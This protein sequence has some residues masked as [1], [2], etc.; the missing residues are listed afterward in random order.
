MSRSLLLATLI[1]I[2]L[3]PAAQADVKAFKSWW[4]T[5]SK[6][7]KDNRRK[8]YVQLHIIR[9][10]GQRKEFDLSA[11]LLLT[12]LQARDPEQRITAAQ[13]LADKRYAKWVK[14]LIQTYDRLRKPSLLLDCEIVTTLAAIGQTDAPVIDFLRKKLQ[15]PELILIRQTLKAFETLDKPA[16]VKPVVR[17]LLTVFPNRNLRDAGS[18]RSA[19]QFDWQRYKELKKPLLEACEVLTGKQFE[20]MEEWREWLSDFKKK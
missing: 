5:E 10:L 1:L 8:P 20:L 2:G 17:Y 15:R 18:T 12:F 13:T 9:S 7:F 19:S 14:A 11:R 4:K 16:C 6:R 3:A